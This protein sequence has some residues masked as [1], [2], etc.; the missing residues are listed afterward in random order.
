MRQAKNK[1]EQNK[2]HFSLK[3][4]LDSNNA[5]N[6]L[7]ILPDRSSW[8]GFSQYRFL[9]FDSENILRLW[10]SDISCKSIKLIQPKC[11]PFNCMSISSDFQRVFLGHDD[12]TLSVIKVSAKKDNRGVNKPHFSKINH[13]AL[14]PDGRFLSTSSNDKLGK[15]FKLK[16]GI[17]S[18]KFIH[19]FNP[20]HQFVLQSE[21]ISESMLAYMS[22]SCVSLYDIETQT[23]GIKFSSFN[24]PL[25]KFFID[26]NL[27]ICLQANS[28]ICLFDIR[29]QSKTGEFQHTDARLN[30]ADFDP[31][32]KKIFYHNYSKDGFCAKDGWEYSNYLFGNKQKGKVTELSPSKKI[33]S[34]KQAHNFPLKSWVNVVDYR[35]PQQRNLEME[36]GSHVYIN[37]IQH[38]QD[39]KGI[40]LGTNIGVHLWEVT[41]CFNIKS[42][43][44]KST[45]SNKNQNIK[46][47]LIPK[48]TTSENTPPP[49]QTQGLSFTSKYSFDFKK[50]VETKPSPKNLFLIA[51][52]K[53][54][55]SVKPEIKTKFKKNENCK[56]TQNYLKAEHKIEKFEQ[57]IS[58]IS[59]KFK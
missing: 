12:G 54:E 44:K 25:K 52:Y 16:Q 31:I 36:L 35:F 34:K 51:E 40:M 50:P 9:S 2:T 53:N 37:D 3:W 55:K 56:Q 22:Q 11:S 26:G 32:S 19:S 14:S 20:G 10:R 30:V 13:I 41:D 27:L 49:N 6:T 5:S 17:V 29:T 4:R 45:K 48:K 15:L 47:K 46:K 28:K 42:C 23:Q 33:L 24:S 8:K 58:N 38:V 1:S 43:N 21:F 57:N 59:G 7:R 39:G 18:P